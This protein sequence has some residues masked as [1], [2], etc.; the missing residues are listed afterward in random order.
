MFNRFNRFNDSMVGVIKRP[1]NVYTWT[2]IYIYIYIYIYIRPVMHIRFS[3]YN[4]KAIA[5]QYFHVQWFNAKGHSLALK[6]IW[7]IC[8]VRKPGRGVGGGGGGREV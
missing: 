3:R 5:F 6:H 8:K 1:C 4:S 7:A 2:C